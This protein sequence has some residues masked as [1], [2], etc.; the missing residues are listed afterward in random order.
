MEFYSAH[1]TEKQVIRDH[2]AQTLEL[3]TVRPDARSDGKRYNVRGMTRKELPEYREMQRQ[4]ALN[5]ES[6]EGIHPA[7]LYDKLNKA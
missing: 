7:E 5:Q 6:K 2:M 4:L 1:A 3:H